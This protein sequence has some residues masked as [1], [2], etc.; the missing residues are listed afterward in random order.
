MTLLG[1][2]RMVAYELAEPLIEGTLF[3]PHLM[4]KWYAMLHVDNV[5]YDHHRIMLDWDGEKGEYKLGKMLVVTSYSSSVTLSLATQ[6]LN[7]VWVMT[8]A[9]VFTNASFI[10]A[11]TRAN[12]F[13]IAAINRG[14]TFIDAITTWSTTQQVD[15]IARTHIIQKD[16]TITTKSTTLETLFIPAA[17]VPQEKVDF[18]TV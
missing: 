13:T 6:I 5:K 17:C 1:I 7:P 9:N 18:I 8:G 15:F 10:T 16:I 4:S 11:T 12:V 3:N 2:P 14:N